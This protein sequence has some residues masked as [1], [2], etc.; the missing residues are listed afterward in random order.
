MR[1]NTY[2]ILIFS[3]RL[4]TSLYEIMLWALYYSGFML[5]GFNSLCFC[6]LA[7]C[8]VLCFN[9]G[10]RTPKK[11]RVIHF[12][13]FKQCNRRLDNW[14]LKIENISNVYWNLEF[15]YWTS[16]LYMENMKLNA[17]L[18]ISWHGISNTGI[19]NRNCYMNYK[20]VGIVYE[21]FDKCILD[22]NF[23][24][25]DIEDINV[26]EYRILLYWNIDI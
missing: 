25:I 16:V 5:S 3:I 22:T 14:K 13:V 26:I 23:R 19:T 21:I 24:C 17:E 10:F 12:S 18:L 1:F 6:V 2:G 9:R 15:D 4:S 11:I 8:F 7:L 20:I